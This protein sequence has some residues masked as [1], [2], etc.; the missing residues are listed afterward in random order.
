MSGGALM[1]TLP[2][3]KAFDVKQSPNQ[4]WLVKSLWTDQAV[5]FI[6]GQP[7]SGKSWLALD[8]AVSVASGTS[9]LDTFSV[10]NPG[11]VLMFPAEDDIKAARDRLSG[12][13]TYRGIDLKTLEVWFIG[14]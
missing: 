3:M 5:G 14:S 13:C 1:S 8:F 12:I 10:E 6:V 7:K 9:V 11:P 4:K 2:T